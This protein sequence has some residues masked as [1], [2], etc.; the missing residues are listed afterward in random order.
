MNTQFKAG[1]SQ[2][3]ITPANIKKGVFLVGIGENEEERVAYEKIDDL[4]VRVVWLKKNDKNLIIINA[5][6]LYFSD[7]ICSSIWNWVEDKFSINKKYII[8]NATHTHCSPHP[9]G[10]FFDG[11]VQDPD[12]QR[13]LLEKIK[14]GIQEAFE[15]ISLSQLY[16]GKTKC[17]IGINRRK[18]IFK[19]EDLKKLHFDKKI[20]NRPNPKSITDSDLYILKVVRHGKVASFL[21]NYACHPSVLRGPFISADFTGRVGSL[22]A[23]SI[24]NDI[25]VFYL[26]GFA[27][28]IRPNLLSPTPSLLSS[29]KKWFIDRIEGSHFE[30]NTSELNIKEIGAQFVNILKTIPEED[31]E[32]IKP[33]FESKEVDINL[34][35]QAIPSKEYFLAFNP[36]TKAEQNWIDYVIK[37]YNTFAKLLFK[38]RRID[39]NRKYSFLCMP[40]EV[41]CE[42]ALMF[43]KMFVPRE[44]IPLGYTDGMVG[45]IP[46]AKAI[47]EGGY[48]VERSYKLFGL[49]CP[50]SDEIEKIIVEGVKSLYERKRSES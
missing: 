35:L 27:G 30:K 42:Y 17:N 12:Y 21:I 6:L 5:E 36:K 46:T 22:L 15:D 9:G 7:Q 16:I 10:N 1:L 28:N 43:K 31:Y 40:G 50:F 4:F 26:Q 24:D 33:E 49:P 3:R 2:I 38:I 37:N 32:E 25:S 29:P 23:K 8:L 11:F 48:E 34:P 20:A 13:F 47:R 39:L 18:L 44:I 41:F 19:I 45:Y 14:K